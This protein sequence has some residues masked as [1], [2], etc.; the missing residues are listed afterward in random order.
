MVITDD[1]WTCPDCNRTFAVEA[2]FR[3]TGNQ[4]AAVRAMHAVEH[5]AGGSTPRRKRGATTTG[6]SITRRGA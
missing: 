6:S 1:R 4:L 3:R 5:R 2:S